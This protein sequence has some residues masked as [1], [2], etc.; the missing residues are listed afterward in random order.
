MLTYDIVRLSSCFFPSLFWH[1]CRKPDSSQ[2]LWDRAVGGHDLSMLKVM[3]QSVLVSL[4]CPGGPIQPPLSRKDRVTQ[5]APLFPEPQERILEPILS[6]LL[7]A[8]KK[9]RCSWRQNNQVLELAC[10]FVSAAS[11]KN[12]TLSDMQSQFLC[13]F[14]P[15]SGFMTEQDSKF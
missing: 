15:L 2:H 8:L 14:L 1:Q 4:W 6:C 11:Q 3:T 12:K 9:K 13:S 7:T 10:V 5:H